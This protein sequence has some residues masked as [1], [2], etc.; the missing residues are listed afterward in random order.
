MPARIIFSP[1]PA[2]FTAAWTRHDD[3]SREAN[4]WSHRLD[5]YLEGW[6]EVNPGKIFS[7]TAHDYHFDDPLVGLFSRWSFPDY[8]ECLQARFACASAIADLAFSIRGPIEGSLRQGRLTFFREA[9]RRAHRCN[10]HHDRRAGRHRETVARPQPA[11]VLRDRREKREWRD[12]C[13]STNPVKDTALDLE[14]VW[15]CPILAALQDATPK[16]TH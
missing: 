12:A 8:F 14:Q 15:V 2:G 9:P 16:W 4:I 13:I 5:R 1:K 11:L 6:A 10:A 3:A 7:A